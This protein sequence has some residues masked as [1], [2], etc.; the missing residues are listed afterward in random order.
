MNAGL[1]YTVKHIQKGLTLL[2]NL[3]KGYARVATTNGR[4]K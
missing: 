2:A 1:T 3:E 4:T